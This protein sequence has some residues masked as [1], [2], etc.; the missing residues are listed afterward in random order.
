MS[1][2]YTH[3]EF[4]ATAATGATVAALNPQ[5]FLAQPSKETTRCPPPVHL[6]PITN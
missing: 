1:P 6:S 2:P 5:T 3:R 4:L